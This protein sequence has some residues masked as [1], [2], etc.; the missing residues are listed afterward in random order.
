MESETG[1]REAL[2]REPLRPHEQPWSEGPPTLK[3]A[4]DLPSEEEIK[5][6]LPFFRTAEVPKKTP[7]TV[8]DARGPQGV[9]VGLPRLVDLDHDKTA[10]E[11][12]FTTAETPGGQEYTESGGFGIITASE[13]VAPVAAKPPPP[14]PTA[15]AQEAPSIEG[16]QLFLAGV[17]LGGVVGGVGVYWGFIGF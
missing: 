14:P 13:E 5:A 6:D 2:K 7:D 4:D 3:S 11:T 10:K 17:A 15:T 9:P 1:I 12:P 8:W 16:W